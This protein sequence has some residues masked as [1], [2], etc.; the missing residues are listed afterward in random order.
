MKIS[1]ILLV[2]LA[3]FLCLP[4]DSSPGP[5]QSQNELELLWKYQA[6][7]KDIAKCKKLIAGKKYAQAE[8]L[9]AKVI[10]ELPEHPEASFL[11][12]EV[13][14]GQGKYEKGLEAMEKAEADFT[15]MAGILHKT[16][17]E[18]LEESKTEREQVERDLRLLRGRLTSAKCTGEYEAL[19]DE[20]HQTQMALDQLGGGGRGEAAVERLEVPAEYRYVHGNLLF[21]LA[22]YQEA[23]DQYLATV[24]IDPKHR[25]AYNNIASIYFMNR[26]YDEALEYLEH[27]EANG[28]EVNREFKQAVLRALGR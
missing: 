3:V 27:A 2:F 26:G 5:L 19:M 1:W 11:L 4:A 13:H 14:Y 6:P 9:L 12:A 18:R 22:R 10:G 23:L 21:K 24:R 20:I 7:N 17:S 8:T 25:A 15:A 28:V 16:Q